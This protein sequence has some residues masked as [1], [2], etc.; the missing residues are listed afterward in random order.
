MKS[1]SQVSAGQLSCLCPPRKALDAPRQW[2]QYLPCET[3]AHSCL[4][5]WRGKDLV[6][7]CSAG[8]GRMCWGGVCVGLEKEEISAHL[9]AWHPFQEHV[10]T[11]PELVLCQ[12]LLGL[13]AS[14]DCPPE[15]WFHSPSAKAVQLSMPCLYT[16]LNQNAARNTNSQLAALNYTFWYFIFFACSFKLPSRCTVQLAKNISCFILI[17]LKLWCTSS[18]E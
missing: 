16:P 18:E 3:R 11:L 9:P 13:L 4:L 1:S 8:T 2:L 6:C 10:L 5:G 12:W 17:A 14:W 7:S 15:V